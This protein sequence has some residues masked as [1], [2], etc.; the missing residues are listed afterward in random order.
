MCVCVLVHSSLDTLNLSF[1]PHYLPIRHD[2]V[3]TRSFAI[4]TVIIRQQTNSFLI[5]HSTRTRASLLVWTFSC[6]KIAMKKFWISHSFAPFKLFKHNVFSFVFFFRQ[7]SIIMMLWLFFIVRVQRLLHKIRNCNWILFCYA[8]RWSGWK[9]YSERNQTRKR[10]EVSECFVAFLT[11]LFTF[12][13]ADDLNSL[14]LAV[15]NIITSNNN[16]SSW[17]CREYIFSVFGIWW[18]RL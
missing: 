12:Q 5:F 6:V 10:N 18:N 1:L 11:L 9:K 4:S 13:S 17:S 14:S 7:R 2:S 15:A 8:W 3:T 16:N